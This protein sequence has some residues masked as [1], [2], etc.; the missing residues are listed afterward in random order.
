MIDFLLGLT[1]SV[2]GAILGV[3]FTLTDF[4]VN[5]I[6]GFQAIISAI[7]TPI[8]YIGQIPSLL[9]Y[10]T[11]ISPVLWDSLITI[12]IVSL[13]WRPVVSLIKWIINFVAQFISK[14]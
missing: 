12:V 2:I 11:G 13:I 9:V 7:A 5:L 6:P 14:A 10:A 4:L 8:Q 1:G 3:F